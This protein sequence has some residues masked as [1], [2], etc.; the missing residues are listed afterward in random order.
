MGYNRKAI[1]EQAKILA[2][3]KQCLAVEE[4]I[5]WLPISKVTFYA[6]FKVDSNELNTIKS[7]IDENKVK[8]KAVMRKRWFR[9][10]NPTLQIA[11]MKLIAT[12]EEA[13]RLNGSSIKLGG[14]QDN[15]LAS[16]LIVEHVVVPL[17]LKSHESED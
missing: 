9:S 3:E 11:L 13:H 17:E 12:D 14:D 16:K 8:V 1:F 2:V 7:L 15:P 6:F 5:A 10:D 4:L